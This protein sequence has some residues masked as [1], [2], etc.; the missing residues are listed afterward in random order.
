[1]EQIRYIWIAFAFFIVWNLETIYPLFKDNEHRMRHIGTNMLLMVLNSGIT[2][3]PFSAVFVMNFALI[4]RHQIGLLNLFSVPLTLRLILAVLVFDGWMY[5]WHVLNHK[6]AIFWRFHRVH[7]T[8]IH[9][10]LSTAIRYHPFEIIIS[11]I[12]RLPIFIILGFNAFDLLIYEIIMLPVIFFQH[13]NFYIPYR[14]DTRLRWLIATPWMHWV[15][16]SEI[17]NETDSNFGV[18][19]SFWDRIGRTFKLRKDPED[20]RY[21]I[22]DFWRQQQLLS[23]IGLLKTPFLSATKPGKS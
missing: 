17:R 6:Y 16:H 9:M 21:G 7:H 3:L 11:N 22:G 8:D 13:S 14:Y 1:M 10:D 20:I 2:L 23:Y 4:E 15:H 5:L 18:I 12:V 19:F